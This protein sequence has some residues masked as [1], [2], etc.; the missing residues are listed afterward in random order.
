M[1]LQFYLL[2][3][4]GLGDKELALVPLTLYLAGLGATFATEWLNDR[5]GRKLTYLAGACVDESACVCI[6]TYRTGSIGLAG[7]MSHV[8]I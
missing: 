5:L 1:Y 2:D 7:L 4:L 3:T 8:E 6:Y